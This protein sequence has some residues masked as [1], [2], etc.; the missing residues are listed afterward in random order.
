MSDGTR[1]WMMGQRSGGRYE[2]VGDGAMKWVMVHGS[3]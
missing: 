1:E 3:G 2:E